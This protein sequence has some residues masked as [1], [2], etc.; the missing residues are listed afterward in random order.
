MDSFVREKLHQWNLGDLVERFN[1]EAVDEESFMLLDDPSIAALIPKIG[2]RVKFKKFHSELLASVGLNPVNNQSCVNH[3]SIRNEPPTPTQTVEENCQTTRSNSTFDVREILETC[4]GAT[5]VTALDRDRFLSLK[6]RRRMVRL[7]VTYLM[8]KFGETPTS[9]TKKEMAL[10]VTTQFPCLKSSVG[11]GYEA[12]Y[13]PARYRHPATGYLEERL[14]NVRKRL[15]AQHSQ[16][17]LSFPPLSQSSSMQRSFPMP[18]SESSFTDIHTMI[19]R[20]KSNRSPQ[21]EIEEI[22]RYTSSWI[23]SSEPKNVEEIKKENPTLRDCLGMSVGFSPFNNQSCVNQ[24]PIRNEPPTPTQTVEEN[25]QTARSNSIFD[26]REILKTCGGA[27]LVTALDR[28]SYLNLKERRRMVRLL[29]TYLMEK[30]GETPTSETKK[31]MALAV[32]TQFPCL[33]S[34]VGNGYEAWYTPARYRHPATGYLEERLRNVRKRLR[35]RQSQKRLSFRPLSQSSPVQRSFPMPEAESPFTDIHTMI[36]RLN[37]N[38]SSH[39]EM[40]EFMRYTASWIHSSEPKTVEEIKKESPTLLECLATIS[41]DFGVLFPEHVGCLHELWLPVFTDR[42]LL[43]AKKEPKASDVLPE[44]LETLEKEVRGE[45]AFK[46]LPAILPTSPY[47]TNGKVVRPTYAE[48][49]SSFIDVQPVGTNMVQYLNSAMTQDPP[50]ILVLGDKEHSSQ[51]YVVFSGQ[52]VEQETLLQA[53]DSC[54][55]LFHVYDMNYPKPSAPIWEFLQHAV[56]NI[57]GGVPSAHCSLLK[58]FVFRITDQQ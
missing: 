17:P 28:D 6:E 33:K 36:E 26:V 31:E 44:N 48:V 11:N 37:N 32:T 4:G 2:P 35:A 20:L 3:S 22:M 49:K 45:I 9:E 25:C 21:G 46:A 10:A 24:S 58:N 41:Q 42:I 18:E 43:L 14:R 55:K 39:D 1:E 13:T 12:W 34:S 15:R 30:F 27:T 38:R 8:E 52:A 57:P 40:E 56:Y 23:H 7:L 29:V 51:V 47:R 54:F 50:H 16:R 53:V 5:L 19:E